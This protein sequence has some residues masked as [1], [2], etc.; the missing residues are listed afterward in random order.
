MR[1]GTIWRQR[2]CGMRYG[3][4]GS[5][6]RDSRELTLPTDHS[7]AALPGTPVQP[8]NI[9]VTRRR[10]VLPSPS[11]VLKNIKPHPPP[12][13]GEW[14]LDRVVPYQRTRTRRRL[15]VMLPWVTRTK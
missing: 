3:A 15:S 12:D 7:H 11:P 1:V 5:P 14:G 4:Y 10:R 13:R 2:D 6:T 9:S 8:A